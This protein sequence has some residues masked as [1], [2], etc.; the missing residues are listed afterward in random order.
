MDKLKRGAFYLLQYQD[1]NYW[2]FII[3]VTGKKV[4]FLSWSESD[5]KWV[6][7]EP[8]HSSNFNTIIEIQDIN[9]LPL[10]DMKD[11]QKRLVIK[12][13]LERSIEDF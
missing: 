10:H 13:I 3:E 4:L 12:I 7:S 8:Y 5:G 1:Q 6:N 9:I 2:A 11:D